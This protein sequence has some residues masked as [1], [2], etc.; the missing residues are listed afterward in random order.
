MKYILVFLFTMFVFEH[1]YCQDPH[2]SQYRHNPQWLNP[3]LVGSFSYQMRV[4]LNYRNQWKNTTAPLNTYMFSADGVVKRGETGILGVG[5]YALMDKA[6]EN[7]LNQSYFGGS[8][9]SGVKL[10][11]N[12]ILSAGISIGAVSIS[13]DPSIYT[14]ESQYTGNGFDNTMDIHETFPEV[15]KTDIDLGAGLNYI[16]YSP[17]SNP[18][19][20]D[21]FNGSFGVSMYHL[22]RPQIP[23]SLSD[24]KNMRFASYAIMSI[25]LEGTNTAIQ[26]SMLFMKQGPSNE[27][28]FGIGARYILREES[29][30]TGFISSSAL[31]LAVDYRVKDAIIIRS[32][33]EVSS[34][35]FGLSYDFNTSD[36]INA[37]DGAGGPEIML[38]Y[39][40][41]LEYRQ[42][43]NTPMI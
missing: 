36:F 24:E 16:I 22:T 26:P 29:H 17:G 23:G 2:F 7:G 14:W 37:S 13:F 15:N 10:S 18:F 21:G 8:I 12:S 11:D 6:G 5:G 31:T 40:L 9:A 1:V 41:P 33:L 19:L 30:Y 4:N 32:L 25:G 39:I 38:R 20:N 35:A 28:V 3:A 27:L 34:F 43:S 42:R